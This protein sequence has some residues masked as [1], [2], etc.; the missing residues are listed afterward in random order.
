MIRVWRILCLH[1]HLSVAVLLGLTL[2]SVLTEFLA[3]TYPTIT[4]LLIA[5]DSGLCIYLL[6]TLR[7]I[8]C[9]A[10]SAEAMR[11]RSR[12]FDEG[13]S[14]ILLLS[15]FTAIL[16]L[17][18]IVI[19]LSLVSEGNVASHV[20]LAAVTVILSWL[21]MH[22]MYALHYAHL[23]YDSCT[24]GETNDIARGILFPGD[25]TAPDYW[26][27]LYFAY[28]IGTSAQTADV[29]ISSRIMRRIALVHCVIAFFFNTT[30][31][32]LAINGAAGLF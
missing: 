19:E 32:A 9:I 14:V 29:N 15:T 2:Y 23:Y 7:T 11:E 24:D 30:V 5:W 4:R 18:G 25:E 3:P 10:S 12:K 1:R 21:F 26:D 6:S 22:L 28:I 31:L 8:S 17:A 27:F 16:S 13:R 20:G